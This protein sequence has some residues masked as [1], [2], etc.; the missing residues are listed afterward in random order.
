MHEYSADYL[1]SAEIESAEE[2]STESA[3]ESASEESAEESASEE[4]ADDTSSLAESSSLCRLFLLPVGTQEISMQ[5]EQDI[6]DASSQSVLS[7]GI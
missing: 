5:N 1:E 7:L 2:S 4:S 3:E 6:L